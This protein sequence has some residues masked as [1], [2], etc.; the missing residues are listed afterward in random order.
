[1]FLKVM[2]H[3]TPY[4]ILLRVFLDD[5]LGMTVAMNKHNREKLDV[6]N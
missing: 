4:N 1:M 2:S 3:L 5:F 6:Y